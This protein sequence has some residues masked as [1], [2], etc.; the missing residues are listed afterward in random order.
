MPALIPIDVT[1]KIT[2]LGRVAGGQDHIRSAQVGSVQASYG[3]ISGE[4]HGGLTRSSCVRV[5]TMHPE[6]T[7]IRNVRQFSIL[8]AEEMQEI[9]TEIGLDRLLPEWLGATMVIKGIGDFTHVPPSSR[10]QNADGTTLVIDMANHACIWP[11]KE[12]EKDHPGLGPKF[13]PAAE[14]RRGVTAW[15]EREGPLRL[16]DE[17]RLH[18]PGQRPWVG[19]NAH[20][21]G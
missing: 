12:I 9:A 5:K 19:L 17:L 14:G 2:W 15:V 3:G 13:K 16:G 6:G 10:L 18:V 8:S 11:G 4:V 7:E 20:L 1:A 21:S